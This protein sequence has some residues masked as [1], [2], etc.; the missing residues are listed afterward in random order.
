MR[1]FLNWNK[2]A[3]FLILENDDGPFLFKIAC[4]LSFNFIKQLCDAGLFNFPKYVNLYIGDCS[5]GCRYLLQCDYV[6]IFLT[7]HV[8]ENP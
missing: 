3:E 1:A 6:P 4:I 7:V 8:V 2:S 5:F